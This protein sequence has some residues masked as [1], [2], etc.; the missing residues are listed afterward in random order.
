M[1]KSVY[2]EICAERGKQIV[3]GFNAAHDDAEH[4]PGNLSQ[5]AMC[6]AEAA[7][8]AASGINGMVLGLDPKSWPFVDG[9]HYEGERESMVKA[10]AMLVAAIEQYDRRNAKNN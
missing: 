2:D 7:T 5:G 6:Y 4:A 10:A 1:Y 8:L 3:K 9:W